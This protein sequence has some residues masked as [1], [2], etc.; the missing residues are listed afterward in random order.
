MLDTVIDSHQGGEGG[1]V[2]IVTVSV[3]D[4]LHLVHATAKSN[5]RV[6]YIRAGVNEVDSPL[7]G[8]DAAHAGRI[9]VP[10]ISLTRV[11]DR[12]M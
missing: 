12:E 2:I 11:D 3:E 7:L 1:K 10:S 6:E 5:Q 9:N 4:P 8:N